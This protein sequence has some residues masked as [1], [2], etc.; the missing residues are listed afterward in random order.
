MAE[1]MKAQIFYEPEKMALE[2]KHIPEPKPSDVLIKVHSVGICGSDVAYYFG[3]SSLETPNGKGPLVL[4]HEFTGDVVAVG[5]EAARVG[6]F[7]VGDRVVANPVQSNPN[8]YWSKKGLSNLCTEKRVLGVSVNGGFAEYTL[9]DYHWTLKLPDHVTYDQGALTEPLACG[10]YAVNNLNAEPGQTAVVFGPGPIGLMMVQ[11]LKSRGLGNVIL[12]GTR[13][14]RLKRGAEL[15]ADGVVNT[16]NPDSPYYVK[17][18]D[19]KI[20]SL[21]NGELADRAITATSSLDAI[22]TALAVTGRHATVVIFGLP[23][24]KDVMQVPILN[25]ILM[26][27]TIRFSWLAPNT[28]EEAVQLISAGAVDMDKIIS[29][30]FPLDE[31]VDGITQVRNREDECT[32][33]L[34]K[35]SE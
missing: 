13:D 20:K 24:D 15:G 26:D 11:V 32:K 21:N 4:G 25:T 8:S 19:E 2:E 28:W 1:S 12:V 30:R 23:G 35:V 10:L 17:D 14:Y 9:S 7:K 29:H 3:K 16:K 22:H 34:V 27:K 5:S 31:L 33:G 18:L 6:G